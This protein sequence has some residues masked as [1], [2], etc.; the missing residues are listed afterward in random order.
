LTTEASNWLTIPITDKEIKCSS[1]PT[2]CS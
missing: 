1:F 2:W